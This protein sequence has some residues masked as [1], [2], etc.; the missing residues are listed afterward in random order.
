MVTL[1]LDKHKHKQMGYPITDKF[2]RVP[3]NPSPI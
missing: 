3:Q 2:N 1:L